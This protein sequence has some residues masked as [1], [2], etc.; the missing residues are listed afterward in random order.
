MVAGSQLERE[1][2]LQGNSLT[3]H[4]RFPARHSRDPRGPLLPRPGSVSFHPEAK[5]S[6]ADMS[7]HPATSPLSLAAC[8]LVPM[9]LLYVSPHLHHFSVVLAIPGACELELYPPTSLLS[10][11]LSGPIKGRLTAQ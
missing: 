3:L 9:S 11:P 10:L 5:L 7:V 2:S 4:R 8:L 1:C 6:V